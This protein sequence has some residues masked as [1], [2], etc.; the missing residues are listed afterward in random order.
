MKGMYRVN[1]CTWD[2][3][4]AK[5]E[6]YC[7]YLAADSYVDAMQQL[8]EYFSDEEMENVKLACINDHSLLFVPEVI[9][10]CI[11]SMSENGF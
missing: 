4:N 5:E 2:N 11:E 8:S 6:S 10:H 1:L 9:T 7:A 3:D